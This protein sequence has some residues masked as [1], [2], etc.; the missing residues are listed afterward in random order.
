MNF[1]CIPIASN[2][3]SI[4]H[5]IQ[6]GKTGIV[7]SELN[8][9]GLEY[10]WKHFIKLPENEKRR[11]MLEGNVLA[12]KFTFEEFAKRLINEVIN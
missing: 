8:S 7:L 10:A 1:G 2:V 12:R 9:E 4:C 11:M 6:H 5:Y 3:G